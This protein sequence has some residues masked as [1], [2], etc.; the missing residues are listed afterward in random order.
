MTHVGASLH[1]EQAKPKPIEKRISVVC[2][3][4][5]FSRARQ[6]FPSGLGVHNPL[7]MC[8]HVCICVC[9][10]ECERAGAIASDPLLG[11]MNMP[12]R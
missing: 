3:Y 9:V 11:L 7:Q 2:F 8:M 6:K 4:S 12:I 5:C 1:V 10:W